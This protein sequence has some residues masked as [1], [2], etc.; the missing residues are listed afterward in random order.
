MDPCELYTRQECK[1]DGKDIRKCLSHI[2]PPS[3]REKGTV[4]VAGLMVGMWYDIEV[5]NSPATT[6]YSASENVA[7]YVVGDDATSSEK[8][9]AL[10]EYICGHVTRM[11]YR[12]EHWEDGYHYCM[13]LQRPVDVGIMTIDGIRAKFIFIQCPQHESVA[14]VVNDLIFIDIGKALY[15]IQNQTYVVDQD[16]EAAIR[17]KVA[18]ISPFV[19]GWE[20]PS[21]GDEDAL[22]FSLER[23]NT[24]AQMGYVIQSYPTVQM[25]GIKEQD[26]HLTA[27]GPIERPPELNHV[28]ES[29]EQQRPLHAIRVSCW[30]AIHM[31]EEVI[32]K[33][34][35]AGN[36]VGVVGEVPLF[37][38]LLNNPGLVPESVVT[39]WDVQVLDVVVCQGVAPSQMVFEQYVLH[40][41]D[42]LRR[43]HW[44]CNFLGFNTES[45]KESNML[46]RVGYFRV[47]GNYITYRVIWCTWAATVQEGIQKFG[48]SIY[49]VQY[50]FRT[51][52]VHV[53]DSVKR[54]L[55]LGTIEVNPIYMDN[56]WPSES[57]IMRVKSFISNMREHVRRGWKFD[58]FPLLQQK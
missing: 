10:M 34:A 21:N 12:L 35:L 30:G 1:E 50:H 54:Q 19:F 44:M 29:G 53:P 13:Y 39:T 9:S 42:S 32:M 31:L 27:L 33:E 11:G 16:V 56:S 3:I 17:N 22:I 20:A 41:V 58:K 37:M 45:I 51:H 18:C 28:R 47:V 40:I 46:A 55:Q 24:L 36:R 49:N 5:L 43:R 4:A 7:V 14:G 52:S 26:P 48:L 6:M 8:F 23:M 2:I 57:D 38:H 15:N 25:E